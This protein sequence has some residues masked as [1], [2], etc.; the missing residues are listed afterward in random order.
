M[1][2]AQKI[3]AVVAI[4][5]LFTVE[6]NQVDSPLVFHFWKVVCNFH[7]KGDTGSSVVGSNKSA[8]TLGWVGLLIWERACIVVGAEKN[9]ASTL[10]L[11]GADQVDHLLLLPAGGV[12]SCKRLI[13]HLQS[14]LSEMFRDHLA[15]S[16]VGC[17]ACGPG[18][19]GTN[20]LEILI[21][22]PPINC[23]RFQ[24]TIA[25]S[26]LAIDGLHAFSIHDPYKNTGQ[27]QAGGNQA[28]S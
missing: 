19:N 10:R 15:L 12:H 5:E 25:R 2:R 17:R 11:P 4:D 9:A 7:E 23:G 27:N 28:G 26:G 1:A 14:V 21:S 6:Q 3:I 13:L 8:S 18:A 16:L 20:L 24:C 22:P